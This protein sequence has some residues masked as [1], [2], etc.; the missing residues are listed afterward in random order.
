[1]IVVR[2]IISMINIDPL[3]ET[4]LRDKKTKNAFKAGV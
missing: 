3:P 4:T 2:T 1:M